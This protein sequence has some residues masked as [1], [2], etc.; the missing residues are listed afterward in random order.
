MTKISFRD[1]WVRKM[2]KWTTDGII[3]ATTTYAEFLAN[4]EAA[5]GVIRKLNTK[6]KLSLDDVNTFLKLHPAWAQC[7]RTVGSS[8][9]PNAFYSLVANSDWGRKNEVHAT[10]QLHG[11]PTVTWEG[12]RGARTKKIDLS[13]EMVGYGS[14]SRAFISTTMGGSMIRARL[15]KDGT[16]VDMAANNDHDAS[17]FVLYGERLEQTR[18]RQDMT[19]PPSGPSSGVMADLMSGKTITCEGG[20]WS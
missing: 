6:N 3:S 1:T 8:Q 11:R 2:I 7:E 5:F 12:K 19:Q 18:N 14:D 9:V 13:M 15:L 20:F 17:R 16:K 10:F 4:P